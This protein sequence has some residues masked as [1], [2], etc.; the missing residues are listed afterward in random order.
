MSEQPEIAKTNKAF[1]LT[2]VKEEAF[3]LKKGNKEIL[4]DDK[5]DIQ[6]SRNDIVGLMGLLSKLDTKIHS[7]KEYKQWIKVRDKLKD[8]FVDDAEEMELTVSEASF[9]KDYLSGFQEREGKVINLDEFEVRTLVGV[10]A[11][12]DVE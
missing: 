7:L 1:S 12:F 8:C 2:L 10:L 3:D 11:Q 6:Y 9:L 5:G 4:K